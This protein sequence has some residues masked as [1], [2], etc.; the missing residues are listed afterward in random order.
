MKKVSK[1][2]RKK[3]VGKVCFAVKREICFFSVYTRFAVVFSTR[4]LD[5]CVAIAL[6][7]RLAGSQNAIILVY[8]SPIRIIFKNYFGNDLFAFYCGDEEIY[9]SKFALFIKSHYNTP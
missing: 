6:I 4:G 5:S 2:E 1:Q 9:C 8:W 7:V 3:Y